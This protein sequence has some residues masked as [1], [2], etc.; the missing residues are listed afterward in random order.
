M[1]NT[2]IIGA[3]GYTG[4][5]LTSLLLDHPEVNL[6]QITSDTFRGKALAEAFPRF[7]NSAPMIFE[8]HDDVDMD[9][10]DAIFLCLP[11]RESMSVA[12]RFIEAGKKVFDLSA[13]FRLKDS[14]VYSEWYN[15]PHTASEY[16]QRSVYGLPELYKG[17]IAGADLVAVPGCYP[18]SA[19][20]ALA[21]VMG[22]DWVDHGSIIIN[23]VSGVSGAGRKT[24]PDYM[25]AELEGNFFAY[26]APNHRHTP[27]IE[28]ELT[29]LA[30]KPV[31]VMFIPHLLPTA[32]GIYSTITIKTKQEVT[33]D[34]AKELYQGF[35]RDSRFVTVCDS[36]P[37][38]KWTTGHNGAFINV[39]VD[40]R[41][42][43]MIIT[44]TL[45]N[46]IKGASGQAVQ[47]FNI[48]YGFDEAAGLS[49]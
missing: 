6:R 7:A 25:F 29:N 8:S 20:L 34:N 30:P 42:G 18:T 27:E 35:Y 2:G 15:T 3:A 26:G 5:E 1:I 16:L 45:D 37:H 46:L 9:Q 23:S 11:H 43:S 32:R 47:C 38:M 21:P 40:K 41:T 36:Y 19:I 24:E 48:S 33:A 13:D 14:A 44:A 12:P 22:V 31:K 17:K 28:Q 10:L 49:G 39:A 4:V